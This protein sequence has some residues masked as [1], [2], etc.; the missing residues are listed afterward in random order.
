MKL[1]LKHLSAYLPYDLKVINAYYSAIDLHVHHYFCDGIFVGLHPRAK[2][3]L[4]PLSDLTKEIEV[5]GKKFVPSSLLYQADKIRTGCTWNYYAIN[6]E[7][8]KLLNYEII[9]KLFEWHFD[10]FN[11]IENGLAIDVNTLEVNP[12]K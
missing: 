9:E 1:E 11:L 2:P 4:H 3:I 5:D 6:N 10:V 8:V 7:N 12:Y